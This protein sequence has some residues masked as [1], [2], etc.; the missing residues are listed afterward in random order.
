MVARAGYT[1]NIFY[2]LIDISICQ[3]QYQHIQE[4]EESKRMRPPQMSSELSSSGGKKKAGSA[5]QTSLSQ[6][7]SKGFPYKRQ[8]QWWTNITNGITV[9]LLKT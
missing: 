2:H 3:Y 5:N 6:A 8:S 4:Y 9:Y 7:F 1:S